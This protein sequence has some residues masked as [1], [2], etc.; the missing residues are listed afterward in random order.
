M[1]IKS[2]LHSLNVECF[3]YKPQDSFGEL[4]EETHIES[5]FS[6]N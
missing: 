1:R 2:K 6:E 5:V 3:T 4:P